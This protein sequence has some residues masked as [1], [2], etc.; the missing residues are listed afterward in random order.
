M[1][2]RGDST[3]RVF[4]VHGA[5]GESTW[6]QLVPG[7][8]IRGPWEAIERATLPPRGVSGLHRHSRTVE[9]YFILEGRGTLTIDG[10]QTGVEAGSLGLVGRGSVHGLTNHG[11]G[12]LEWLVAEVPIPNMVRIAA[13]GEEVPVSRDM[14]I[15]QVIDLAAVGSIDLQGTLMEPLRRIGIIQLPTGRRL[16]LSAGTSEIFLYVLEGRVNVSMASPVGEAG[17]GAGV[18][19]SLGEEAEITALADARCFWAS[20]AVDEA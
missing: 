2:D 7:H 14:P 4:A 10:H 18:T 3:N 16:R 15:P 1:I 13:R 17:K 19:L 5:S 20:V 6:Q 11:C 8:G 12:A 9:L